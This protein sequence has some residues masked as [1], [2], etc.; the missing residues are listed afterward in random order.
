MGSHQTNLKKEA[1][2]MMSNTIESRVYL[3]EQKISDLN[4]YLRGIVESN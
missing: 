1:L 2:A 3:I 4:G